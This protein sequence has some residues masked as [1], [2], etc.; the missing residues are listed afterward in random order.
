MILCRCPHCY[1]PHLISLVP[2]W[3]ED[4]TLSCRTIL[5][6]QNK[7]IH[8]PWCYTPTIILLTCHHFIPVYHVVTWSVV[9]PVIVILKIQ[10][11]QFSPSPLSTYVFIQRPS[12]YSKTMNLFTDQFI[13]RPSVYPQTINLFTD[14]Q[15]IHKPLIYSQTISLFTDHQFI[16]RPSVYPQTISL[17]TDHQFIYRPLFYP[18]TFI[19]Y[20][21]HHV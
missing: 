4:T 5:S 15:F 21:D 2:V 16:H 9:Y 20:I 18:H 19:L 14:H 1:L 17:S 10:S 13:H 8:R 12:V 11:F 3:G 7:F 6:I